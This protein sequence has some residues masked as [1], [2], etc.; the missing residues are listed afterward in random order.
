MKE[1]VNL[2]QQKVHTLIDDDSLHPLFELVGGAEAFHGSTQ[3]LLLLRQP[4]L[5]SGYLI[6]QQLVLTMESIKRRAGWSV[7]TSLERL[8]TINS[9]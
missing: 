5:Q 8:Q 4:A 7:D 9:V 2:K 6:F 3:H 1:T